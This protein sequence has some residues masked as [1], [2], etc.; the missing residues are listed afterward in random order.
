MSF[1]VILYTGIVIFFE[2][3]LLEGAEKAGTAK[4]RRSKPKMPT[5]VMLD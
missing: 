5:S 1:L 2:G 3:T 4:T